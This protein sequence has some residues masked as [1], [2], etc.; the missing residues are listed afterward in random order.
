MYKS[1]VNVND[2]EANKLIGVGVER[3]ITEVSVVWFVIKMCVTAVS[4]EP[5]STAVER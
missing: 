4:K 3:G 5:A 1:S 2:W